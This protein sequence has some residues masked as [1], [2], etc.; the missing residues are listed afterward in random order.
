MTES[1]KLLS[2]DE[3]ERI[4]DEAAKEGKEP[5]KYIRDL[6]EK[7]RRFDS[8]SRSRDRLIDEIRRVK[9][10]GKE[11]EEIQL[12]HRKGDTT[13]HTLPSVVKKEIRS[14][15]KYGWSELSEVDRENIWRY[16]WYRRR[17]GASDE[18]LRH[19]VRSLVELGSFHLD[20]PISET[21]LDEFDEPTDRPGR[22]VDRFFR[23]L[24]NHPHV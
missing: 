10:G 22:A 4:I 17:Q 1:E 12:P 18:K 19:E 7:G 8:V 16:S 24:G 9:S 14:R 3:R 15:P 5:E 23:F 11:L 20:K 2:S 6:L 21:K 13:I